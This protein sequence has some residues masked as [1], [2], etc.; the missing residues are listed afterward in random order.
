MTVQEEKRVNRSSINSPKPNEE[1]DMF[2]R[3]FRVSCKTK[4]VNSPRLFK[5]ILRVVQDI[6]NEYIHIAQIAMFENTFDYSELAGFLDMYMADLMEKKIIAQYDI[7][8]D[9]RNNS[10]DDVSSGRINATIKFNCL[11][12]TVIDFKFVLA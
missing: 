11:N 12:T 6:C 8:A 9:H 3:E 2:Q 1:Q 10:P 7:V 4:N 5:Q